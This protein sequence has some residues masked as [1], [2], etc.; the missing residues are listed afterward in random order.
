MRRTS[1]PPPSRRERPPRWRRGRGGSPRRIPPRPPRVVLA[2]GWAAVDRV[3]SLSALL[4]RVTLRPIG[5]HDHRSGGPTDL[6]GGM[7]VQLSA[8]RDSPTCGLDLTDE[9]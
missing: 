4:V 7:D 9:M 1:P 6:G 3:P 5:R 2:A 8:R